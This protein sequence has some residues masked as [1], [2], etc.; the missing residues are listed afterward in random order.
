ML[1]SKLTALALSFMTMMAPLPAQQVASDLVITSGVRASGVVEV[2]VYDV[3]TGL[4]VNISESSWLGTEPPSVAIDKHGHIAILYDRV[5]NKIALYSRAGL[6]VADFAVDLSTIPHSGGFGLTDI[7]YGSDGVLYAIASFSKPLFNYVI[8]ID[9]DVRTTLRFADL[10]VVTASKFE[11]SR[12]H[13]DGAG[14]L[15][16]TEWS[17]GGP[18]QHRVITLDPATFALL[19][20]DAGPAI[21][22]GSPLGAVRTTA[23]GAKFV[24]DF[25]SGTIYRQEPGSSTWNVFLST[26]T[27][28]G[29]A[30]FD[31]GL[32]HVIAA[33]NAA[34]ATPDEIWVIDPVTATVKKKF[35]MG[36][37]LTLGKVIFYP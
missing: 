24:A 4:T 8:A 2:R 23:G 22:G 36:S 30:Y 11:P 10:D 31:V 3:A 13:F 15:L 14:K 28:G 37:G 19:A 18:G 1:G 12:M 27:A 26:G 33:A 35:A 9:Q 29:L 16:V 6:R 25:N 21:A 34:G 7:E 20:T 32:S 17:G 5:N